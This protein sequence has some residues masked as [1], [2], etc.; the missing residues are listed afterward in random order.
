[1]STRLR[2]LAVI[3]LAATLLGG[4]VTFER[5]PVAQ[6][7]CDPALAGEWQGE[8]NDAPSQVARVSPDCELHW[9]EDD[10]GTYTTTLR[11]FTLDDHRYL[12]FSPEDADRLMDMDGDLAAQAPEG[13]VLFARY[14]IDGD[15]LQLWLA[16]PNEALRTGGKVSARQIEDRFAHVEGSRED[17]AA[18]LHERGD[19]LF[20]IDDVDGAA[21][22][23]RV[24]KET[25]P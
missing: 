4:C 3:A 21:R 6:L 17:I 25:A 8:K 11:G 24:P 22:F 2:G 14:R 18:L 16:D 10:G 23:K 7:S 13:S 1:M 20:D 15:A 19:T 5:A 9:P 12:V